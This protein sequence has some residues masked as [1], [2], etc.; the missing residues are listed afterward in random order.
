ML[1][2]YV[3][4]QFTPAAASQLFLELVLNMEFEAWL[5]YSYE[6]LALDNATLHIPIVNQTRVFGVL[7]KFGETMTTIKRSHEQ[8]T[9]VIWRHD[10]EYSSSSSSSS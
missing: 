5:L 4:L 1:V 7:M 8:W 10:T 3:L 9:G 2:C 6:F